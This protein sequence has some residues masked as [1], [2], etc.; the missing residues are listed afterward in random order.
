MRSHPQEVIARRRY[1]TSKETVFRMF[2]VPTELERW[3]SPSEDIDTEI[4]ELDLREGGSYRFGFQ[5][6]DGSTN[7]VIGEYLE[8]RPPGRLVFTWT[9]EDPDPHAGIETLVT[10]ELVEEGDVTEV[11]VT[12]ARLP[13][14]ETRERHEEGWAGALDG[15]DERLAAARKRSS[16]PSGRRTG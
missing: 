4:E 15:L 10:V 3:F 2:T 8:I 16:T 12:H 14:R 13:D 5:F 11:T 7:H 1:R 6:P 9:W